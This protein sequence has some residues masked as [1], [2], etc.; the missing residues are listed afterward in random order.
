MNISIEIFGF[1]IK[2][3]THKIKIHCEY[4]DPMSHILIGMAY[5]WWT[6]VQI[7]LESPDILS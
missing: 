5:S 4:N 3:N 7:S 2:K 1:F 6:H